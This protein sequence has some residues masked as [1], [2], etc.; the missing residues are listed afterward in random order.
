MLGRLKNLASRVV[1]RC[2]RGTV[3]GV[4]AVAATAS[5]ALAQTPAPALDLTEATDFLVDVRAEVTP[6][7]IA[8]LT[9]LLVIGFLFWVANK[10]GARGVKG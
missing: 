2:R 4:V 3:A 10:A 9:F 8:I 1:S 5:S 7:V 6:V